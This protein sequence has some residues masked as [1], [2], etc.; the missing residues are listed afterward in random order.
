[1][2]GDQI[3]L[4][5]S[6]YA[7]CL[8]G[9]F[10][11][12]NI[13]HSHSLFDGTGVR[14]REDDAWQPLRER[15]FMSSL[16][17]HQGGC[18][19]GAIRFAAKGNPVL[20]TICHCHFCQR[21]TGSAYLVEPI[22]R[23]SDFSV[24]NGSPQIY[25]AISRGSGKRVSLHFCSKCG[26]KTHQTMARFPGVVGIWGGTLDDPGVAFTAKDVWR[27]FIDDAAKGTVISSNVPIWNQHRLDSEGRPLDST[28]FAE[29]HMIE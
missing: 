14:S 19:C 9:R 22:W 2:S 7:R 26:T 20:L 13:K 29:M 28:F 1:M 27:I 25:E 11:L 12:S 23:E 18:L 17:E 16:A 8:P 3:R 15:E 6:H 21:A 24:T 4:P 10:L 5:T